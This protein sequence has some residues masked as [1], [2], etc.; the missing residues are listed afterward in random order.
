[1]TCLKIDFARISGDWIVGEPPCSSLSF[2]R[3]RFWGKDSSASSSFGK[4]SQKLSVG[5]WGGVVIKYGNSCILLW[6]LKL[7][8]LCTLNGWIVWSVN[9]ISIKLLVKKDFNYNKCQFHHFNIEWK[10]TS[11]PFT[12][13]MPTKMC[14]GWQNQYRERFRSHCLRK[15][16]MILLLHHLNRRVFPQGTPLPA[17]FLRARRKKYK[18]RRKEVWIID[19]FQL[20]ALK[21]ESWLVL[22]FMIKLFH[23]VSLLT[24]RVIL[25]QDYF[26]HSNYACINI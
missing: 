14:H 26:S 21:S 18:P 4:W 9:Y 20:A 7:T 19:G 11:C 22:I 17:L 12:L 10:R 16:K 8:D 3:S 13:D 1:M 23:F 15:I 6:I 2:R 25:C 5:I 24:A